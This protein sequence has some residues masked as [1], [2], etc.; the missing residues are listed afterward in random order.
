VI[1]ARGVESW[2]PMTK[3]EVA[4]GIVQRVAV[5]LAKQQ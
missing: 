5:E 3:A 2:P 1:D 4:H